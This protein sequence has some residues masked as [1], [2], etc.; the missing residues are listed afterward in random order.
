MPPQDDGQAALSSKGY[1]SFKTAEAAKA[2]IEEMDKKQMGDNSYLLVSRH[3]SKRENQV[4]AQNATA[5]A[6]I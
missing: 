2:A 6:T 5:N 1:V 4:A 3:I